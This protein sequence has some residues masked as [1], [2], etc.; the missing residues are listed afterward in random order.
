MLFPSRDRRGAVASGIRSLTV[1]APE[2][3]PFHISTPGYGARGR[4]GTLTSI[5]AEMAR[6]LTY[7]LLLGLAAIPLAA[8][9]T[10]CACDVTRP[11]TLKARECSLC[12]EAEKHP[13]SVAY[14]LL[15]TSIP[16]KPNR[17]LA[18]PQAHTRSPHACISC[19]KTRT[20]FWRYAIEQA[21]E[22][23][24]GEWGGL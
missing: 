18:L 6:T 24:G 17:W 23:F 9:V 12:I 10:N 7:L 4:A 22:R 19:R 16:R 1:A 8:D 15:R 2:S 21:E 3:T 14:F 5:M 13:A 20:R 11:E